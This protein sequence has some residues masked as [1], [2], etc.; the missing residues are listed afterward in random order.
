MVC[1]VHLGYNKD[2]EGIHLYTGSKCELLAQILVEKNLGTA[3][4]TYFLA[5]KQPPPK[6]SIP[7][8]PPTVDDPSVDET[9]NHDVGEYTSLTFDCDSQYL[10]SV[11]AI[12]NG[13]KSFYV[14]QL[15]PEFERTR[16]QLNLN[17]IS[18]EVR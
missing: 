9:D 11:S 8:F 18:L 13:V 17:L 5:C 15:S 3:A 6:M 7:S 1:A 12:E 2:Y 10:V 4:E 16:I 14:H